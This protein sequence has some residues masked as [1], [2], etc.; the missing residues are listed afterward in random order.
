MALNPDAEAGSKL[1]MPDWLATKYNSTSSV[2]SIEPGATPT[3]T[4]TRMAASSFKPVK[5]KTTMPVVGDSPVDSLASD[6]TTAGQTAAAADIS[7]SS[8]AS[9]E[10]AGALDDESLLA[11]QGNPPQTP[12]PLKAALKDDAQLTH[13]AVDEAAATL[14]P[15]AVGAI[16][17]ML[18]SEIDPSL[19][20]NPGTDPYSQA[21][22]PAGL[23]G[24][25]LEAGDLSPEEV[26][27]D[28]SLTPEADAVIEAG[29]ASVVPSVP[30]SEANWGQVH[31]EV[32]DPP[33][34][35]S[36]E[37]SDADVS[38]DSFAGSLLSLQSPRKSHSLSP[39]V[40]A[41]DLMCLAS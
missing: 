23:G 29:V 31:S 30:A 1:A 40:A 3:P 26:D 20:H 32:S 11:A 33:S 24:K 41:F 27:S 13:Q 16:D 2:A 28:P 15:E 37:L 7:M 17:T 34:I 36:D 19:S 39:L 9:T 38:T 5:R 22:S 6:P 25:T 18:S 21:P 12:A 10:E 4:L 35:A 14:S 8:P